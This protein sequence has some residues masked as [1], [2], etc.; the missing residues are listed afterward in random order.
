VQ[1]Y[2]QLVDI[3]YNASHM[4]DSEVISAFDTALDCRDLSSEDRYQFSMRKLEYLEELGSDPSKYPSN[5]S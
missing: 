1:L 5:R 3:S 4:R 2:L